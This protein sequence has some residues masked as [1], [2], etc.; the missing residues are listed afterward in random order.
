MAGKTGRNRPLRAFREAPRFLAN[1]D[2][3]WA[4]IE[5]ACIR[6]QET[7]RNIEY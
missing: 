2:E 4:Q 1:V 5:G 6:Q 7:E 3:D